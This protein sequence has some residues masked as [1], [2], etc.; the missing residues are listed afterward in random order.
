LGPGVSG[1]AIPFTD[2]D[3]SAGWN[4]P[5]PIAE[6][7][8]VVPID[9]QLE[10]GSRQSRSEPGT[11]PALRRITLPV[12]DADCVNTDELYSHLVAIGGTR[13]CST[14]VEADFEVG[15][16]VHETPQWSPIGPVDPISD[17]D[18]VTV[19]K[20]LALMDRIMAVI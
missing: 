6:L 2:Y 13:G 12:G 16:Q 8:A 1:P 19:R 11:V 18:A 20:D 14:T 10:C 9:P 17:R 4:S 15:V 3:R 5:E 7:R